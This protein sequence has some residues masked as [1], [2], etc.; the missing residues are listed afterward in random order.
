MFYGLDC[1]F[2]VWLSQTAWCIKCSSLTPFLVRVPV[3]KKKEK[4]VN[5]Q[6]IEYN[7]IYYDDGIHVCIVFAFCVMYLIVTQ[8]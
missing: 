3:E 2:A 8:Y 7:V 4:D 1:L 6:V 5:E